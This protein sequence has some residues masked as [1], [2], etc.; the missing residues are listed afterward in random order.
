MRKVNLKG[1][2][3]LGQ[4]SARQR[5]LFLWPRRGNQR[6]V[7]RVVGLRSSELPQ[8]RACLTFWTSMM[9]QTWTDSLLFYGR[10]DNKPSPG[11][12]LRCFLQRT[13]PMPTL[14]AATLDSVCATT[15]MTVYLLDSLLPRSVTPVSILQQVIY[16]TIASVQAKAAKSLSNMLGDFPCSFRFVLPKICLMAISCC[17]K[18]IQQLLILVRLLLTGTLS[19]LMAAVTL[20]VGQEI[21]AL[22]NKIP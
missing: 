5:L 9:P 8:E 17:Q 18:V 21:H 7:L 3:V 19:L 11:T 13:S 15:Y 14:L 1:I 4:S 22:G 10:E 2:Q 6:L 12:A 16:S 20:A